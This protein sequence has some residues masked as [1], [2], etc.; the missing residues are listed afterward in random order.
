MRLWQGLPEKQRGW[1]WG[2]FLFGFGQWF[3]QNNFFSKSFN[4]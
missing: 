4:S 1:G 2:G 3:Q